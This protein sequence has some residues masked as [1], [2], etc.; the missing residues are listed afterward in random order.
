MFAVFE[1]DVVVLGLEGLVDHVREVG[2]DLVVEVAP[3]QLAQPGARPGDPLQVHPVCHRS[4]LPHGEGAKAQVHAEVAGPFDGRVVAGLVVAVD[5]LHEILEELVRALF[6]GRHLELCGVDGLEVDVGQAWNGR[7]PFAAHR[8]GQGAQR[9][10]VPGHRVGLELETVNLLEPSVLVGREDAECVA[11][12]RQHLAAL[13]DHVVLV[14]MEHDAFMGQLTQHVRIA[15][16]GGR[17]VVVVGEHGLHL[18]LPGQGGD[19]IPR[20]RV[21]HDQSGGFGA[22]L[23][24]H[25]PQPGIQLHKGLPYEGHPPVGGQTA[26]QQRLQ[27]VGVQDEHTPHLTT[28]FE[29]VVERGVVFGAQVAP[30]PH[31]A[32]VV[33]VHALDSRL[34]GGALRTGRRLK[35]PP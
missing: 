1:L 3:D 13:E 5:A 23:A 27:D 10:R 24:T 19:C 31:Q 6:A 9:G 22:V 12:L 7:I 18:Q 20:A 2:E 25:R 17:F 8:A 26:R 15:R 21:A 30:E 34:Q 11:R 29:G 32:F 28:A 33:G 16:V 4:R 14:P 35:I